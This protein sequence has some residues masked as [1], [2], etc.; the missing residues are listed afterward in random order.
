MPV[1]TLPSGCF[2]AL[3]SSKPSGEESL[4]AEDGRP[5]VHRPI[6]VC[7]EKCYCTADCSTRGKWSTRGYHLRAVPA[8]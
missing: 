6:Q 4:K 5:G 7:L 2:Q 8:R 1:S 3:S